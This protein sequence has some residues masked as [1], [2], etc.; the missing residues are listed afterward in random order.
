VSSSGTFVFDMDL[1]DRLTERQ[2]VIQMPR[3]ERQ[4][5]DV[6]LTDEFQCLGG[7]WDLRPIQSL[8]LQ[9]A[10]ENDGLL[11]S[12]GVGAGKTLLDCLLPTAME[13]DRALVLIPASRR[14]EFV[15]EAIEYDQHFAYRDNFQ[16]WSYA[17]ISSRHGHER[18]VDYQPDLIVADEAHKLKDRNSAR[19]KRVL[20]YFREFPETSLCAYSGTLTARS[21][22]DYSHLSELAL[23]DRSPVPRSHSELQRWSLAIDVQDGE[24]FP[25]SGDYEKLQPLVDKFGD[26]RNLEDETNLTAR[27]EVRR[28]YLERLKTTPGVVMTE[29]ASCQASILVDT[30]EEPDPPEEVVEAFSHLQDTWEL[31]DGSLV[32]N[33][34]HVAKHSRRILQGF[35]YYWDWTVDPWD[36]QEDLDWLSARREYHRAVRDYCRQSIPGRDTPAL[37]REALQA[38]DIDSEH[39]CRVWEIWDKHRHKPKP[40]VRTEWLSDYLI[41]D[42]IRWAQ[43]RDAIVWY[44]QKAVARRLQDHGLDVF[45]ANGREPSEVDQARPVACSLDAHATGANLQAWD[46]NIVMSPPP[47]GFT[48]EQLIGRT[49]RAGQ[50]AD[51]IIIRPYANHHMLINALEKAQNDARYLEDTTG[52]QQRLLLADWT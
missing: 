49:H 37:V 50:T 40:P 32:R 14:D 23:G 26:G 13:A 18:L 34:M 11:A 9:Q 10:R 12:I 22:E 42:V 6:D 41:E 51:E 7:D 46:T 45:W 29:S 16:L 44:D 15:T 52:Q 17:E 35:Y 1:S 25:S 4:A 8:A 36:G 24:S 3:D 43:R 48:W 39:L 21:I 2:R 19:T 33:Q 27:N 47:S 38:G 20:R 30:I 31:P 28:A 5:G